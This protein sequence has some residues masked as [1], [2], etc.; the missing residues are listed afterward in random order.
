MMH[1]SPSKV[2]LLCLGL[3]GCGV[4]PSGLVSEINYPE[5]ESAGAKLLISRCS[6]CHGAPSPTTHSAEVWPG[7]VNRMQTRLTM[8]AYDPLTE[9][10]LEI[11]TTYLQKHAGKELE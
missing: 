7:V 2:L 11:L 10:E 5:P 3:A 8:K 1:P 9:D 4:Q 6:A